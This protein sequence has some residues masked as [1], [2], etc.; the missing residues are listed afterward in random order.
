MST[1]ESSV[2]PK[3]GGAPFSSCAGPKSRSDHEIGNGALRKSAKKRQKAPSL[4]RGD[5]WV[6]GPSEG[7]FWILCA[8]SVH[9]A[10]V[11]E[12]SRNA[13][14]SEKKRPTPRWRGHSGEP[15]RSSWVSGY[16]LPGNMPLSAKKCH[17][18]GTAWCQTE[19]GEVGCQEARKT[20]VSQPTFPVPN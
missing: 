6:L 9:V 8:R 2:T 20:P 4:C 15:S 17:S 13:P 1:N 11:D 16:G 12:I 7:A 14:P 3:A 10:A 18:F 5:R 19:D